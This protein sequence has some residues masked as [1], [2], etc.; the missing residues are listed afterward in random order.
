MVDKMLAPPGHG[1]Y[2]T[3]LVVN[4]VAIPGVAMPER[5]V[6]A[7]EVVADIRS[8]MDDSALME[9]YKL[10][11][12]GLQNLFDE[13]GYLG[14]LEQPECREVKPARQRI[15]AKAMVQDIR[16]GLSHAA[17]AEKFKLSAKG[18]KRAFK[19][20]A[21][22]GMID[23]VEFREGISAEDTVIL[24]NIR[25]LRRYYLDFDLPIIQVGPPELKGRVRDIT[26]K[27][28][29]IIGIPAEVDEIRTFLILHEKFVLIKPFLFDAKCRWI[30]PEQ[31]DGQCCAGFQITN[32]SEKDVVELKKLVRIVSFMG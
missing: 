1:H 14:Y 19:K 5:K 25:E 3:L 11:P 20:L 28:V 7:R 26:E 21:E 4:T 32:T 9:K 8:G 30:A 12:R 27:G 2:R 29:G 24:E 15:S 18:L 22:S 31:G 6:K 10:T 23:P 13:L 16:A 17:L